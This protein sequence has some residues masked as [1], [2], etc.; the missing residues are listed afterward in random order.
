[1]KPTNGLAEIHH[2]REGAASTVIIGDRMETDSVAGIEAGIETGLV[3]SGVTS[4]SDLK[5]FA[6]RPHHVLR[7]LGAIL[8]STS[9]QCTGDAMTFA[10]LPQRPEG[11]SVIVNQAAGVDDIEQTL[12][13][14]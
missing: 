10:G 8:S 9:R 12:V 2:R 7:N 5:R 3:L 4:E 6:C 13:R 11:E 1:M 14:R